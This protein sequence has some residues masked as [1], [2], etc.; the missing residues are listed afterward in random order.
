MRLYRKHGLFCHRLRGGKRTKFARGRKAAE[1]FVRRFPVEKSREAGKGESPSP[2]GRLACLPT[3]ESPVVKVL[4][5]EG[6]FYKFRGATT[7]LA[8]KGETTH[9]DL[10]VALLLQ[11][12]FAVHARGASNLRTLGAIAP[13]NFRTLK[14]HWGLSIRRVNLREYWKA[15]PRSRSR[16]RRRRLNPQTLFMH[17]KKPAHYV[18]VF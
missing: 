5:E 14:P 17:I 9:Y 13:S 3:G 7:T 12:M 10:C 1:N 8:P 4:S 18:S 2:A 11:I 16:P 15:P 6:A